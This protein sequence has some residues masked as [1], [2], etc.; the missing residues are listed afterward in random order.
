MRDLNI[1]EFAKTITKLINK[2]NLSREESYNAFSVVLN[3]ETSEI[4]QGAFLAALSAKGETK[5]EIAGCWQ[6]IYEMD[7]VKVAPKVN[8]PV[9]ENCGTGMD[10]FKTFNISTCA[11]LV[12]A[13]EGIL[14]ARHGA[15]AL[16]SVC[17]TVDMAEALGV[18]VECGVDI[19]AKSLETTG[20]A[21]FNGMSPT[22][23]PNALGR[24]LSQIAFGSTLNIAASLASPVQPTIGV[25]GVYSKDMIIPV[26]EVM[27]EIGYERAIVFNGHIDGQ[28]NTMDEASVSG[29]T[30]CAEL[31]KDGSIREFSFRP[32][33]AG[34]NV[35]KPEELVPAIDISNE[36][37]AFL[38]LIQGKENNARVDAVALNAG[39]IFYVTDKAKTIAEGTAMAKETLGKAKAYDVLKEWVKAQN[40]NPEDGLEKLMRLSNN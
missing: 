7:T 36:S 34:I 5:E 38:S 21:L 1:R 35:Q 28:N 2:E 9:V 11:S 18:D 14:V 6:A 27:K 23:H 33:E 30:Y 16:T 20:L 8:G 39:L 10:S 40:R 17:G 4:Q 3:N 22:V 26:I 25:R 19:A 31:L 32:E 12:A 13:A 24:I 37:T 29:I 15:R